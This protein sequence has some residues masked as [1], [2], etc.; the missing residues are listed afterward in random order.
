M[1]T[2]IT[3]AIFVALLAAALIWS[4]SKS[5]VLGSAE[6]AAPEPYTP[7]TKADSTATE[8]TSRT[9]ITF[10]VEVGGWKEITINE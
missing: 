3:D 2:R 9:P 5:T 6:E 4:C 1:K 7:R 8:D 10:T